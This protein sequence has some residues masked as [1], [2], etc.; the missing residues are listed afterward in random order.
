M[1]IQKTIYCHLTDPCF[2]MLK[3]TYLPG[4]RFFSQVIVIQISISFLFFASKKFFYRTI[5]KTVF[6][7]AL[8]YGGTY[9]IFSNTKKKV[10]PNRLLPVVE[11]LNNFFIQM[12]FKIYDRNPGVFSKSCK[13]WRARSVAIVC[14]RDIW[15]F[16]DKIWWLKC[17]NLGRAAQDFFF[18]LHSW[19]S[20]IVMR[21]WW[22]KSIFTLR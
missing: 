19:F 22:F 10:G 6:N 3:Y 17:F 13:S 1:G 7:K 11:R 9:L 5:N 15:S 12:I 21:L 20:S 18:K 14:L 16:S 8:N 4:S 2:K